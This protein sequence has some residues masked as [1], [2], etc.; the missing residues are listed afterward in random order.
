MAARR[1]EN[2]KGKCR[3][4]GATLVI[5]GKNYTTKNLYSLPA[6]RN[7]YQARSKTN[8]DTIESCGVLI[9]L[10]NF[11]PAPFTINGINSIHQ[12]N[13]FSSRS[14]TCVETVNLKLLS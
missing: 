4:D 12:N 5:K 9:P 6:E 13:L 3:M 10:S 11:H 1:S 7:R 14:V 8:P 2:Y